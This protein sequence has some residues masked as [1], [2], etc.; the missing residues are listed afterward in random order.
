MFKWINPFPQNAILAFWAI[1]GSSRSFWA[2]WENIIVKIGVGSTSKLKTWKRHS[3]ILSNLSHRRK[4]ERYRAQQNLNGTE[5]SLTEKAT[6]SPTLTETLSCVIKEGWTIDLP[7]TQGL[8]GSVWG[9]IRKLGTELGLMNCLF[10]KGEQDAK[11]TIVSR[12]YRKEDC[13]CYRLCGFRECQGRVVAFW[14]SC[15]WPGRQTSRR[16]SLDLQVLQGWFNVINE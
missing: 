5:M 16:S 9:K 12:S 4:I 2:A 1:F 13:T 3:R 7:K 14:S 8:S 15:D 10:C 6:G 11:G